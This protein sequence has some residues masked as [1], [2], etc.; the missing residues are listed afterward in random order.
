[1]ALRV[2][3]VSKMLFDEGW[4]ELQPSE[5]STIAGGQ[6]FMTVLRANSQRSSIKVKIVDFQLPQ[7]LVFGMNSIVRIGSGMMMYQEHDLAGVKIKTLPLNSLDN[8]F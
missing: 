3:S 2:I 6:N 8:Q 5:I 1:M 4:Y 7:E